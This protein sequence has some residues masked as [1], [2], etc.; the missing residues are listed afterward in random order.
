[1]KAIITIDLEID[2]TFDSNNM[3]DIVE[4]K[5][6]DHIFSSCAYEI[7]DDCVLFVREA[8]VKLEDSSL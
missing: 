7:D 3:T 2:G 4:Q 6:L 8:D 5:I 1:M